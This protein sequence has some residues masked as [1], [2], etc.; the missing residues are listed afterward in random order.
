MRSVVQAVVSKKRL[1]GGEPMSLVELGYSSVGID[2]GW[3][4]CGKGVAGT[5]HDKAGNPIVN[6]RFPDMKALTD[7]SHAQGV[8]K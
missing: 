2:D 5:F 7:Y 4:D 1:V 6:N 3:Q 8:T